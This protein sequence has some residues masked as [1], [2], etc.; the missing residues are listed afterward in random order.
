MLKR[1]SII[2]VVFVMLASALSLSAFATETANAEL[3]IAMPPI[4]SAAP[5][6]IDG[7]EVVTDVADALEANAKKVQFKPMAFVENL[8]IMLIGMLGIFLVI[9]AI[10]I[11]VVVLN[12][13]TAPKP[14]AKEE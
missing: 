10:I 6:A 14:A 4:T 11:S 3:D 2:A 9:G 13:A 8:N 7:A 5:G 12:K 1:I